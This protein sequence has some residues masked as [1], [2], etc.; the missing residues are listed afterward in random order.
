MLAAMRVEKNDKETE[1]ARQLRAVRQLLYQWSRWDRRWSVKLGYPS[2]V[3]YVDGIKGTINSYMEGEDYD[4]VIDTATMRSVDKAIQDDLTRAQSI[5][6]RITYLNE[7]G[8]AVYRSN[9]IP[10]EQVKRLCEEAELALI[11]AFRRR[12]VKL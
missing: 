9:R 8:P 2:A 3:P 1:A 4:Q 12:N 10:R 11:P 6:V 5:A 7:I